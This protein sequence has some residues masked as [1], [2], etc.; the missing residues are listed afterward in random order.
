MSRDMQA[1]DGGAADE[2]RARANLY[3]LLGRLFYAPPDEALLGEIRAQGQTGPGDA[4]DE[5]SRAWGAL[6]GAAAMPAESASEEHESLFGGVGKAIVT[7][8]T[9]AYALD[10]APDKHLVALRQTLE[11]IGLTRRN[12]VFEVEDHIAALCDVMRL[13]IGRGAPLTEQAAFFNEF[14]FEG[15]IALCDALERTDHASFYRHVAGLTRA[16]L[17][18]EQAAFDMVDS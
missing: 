6:V 17:N 18:L 1:D 10:I 8:Y 14:V 5:F 13:L 15:S 3:A 12:M 7:P 4:P 11:E 16:F 2:E 9:S